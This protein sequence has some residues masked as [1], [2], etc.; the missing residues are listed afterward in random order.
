MRAWIG[1]LVLAWWVSGAESAALAQGK[2]SGEAGP[3]TGA[4]TGPSEEPAEAPLPPLAPPPYYEA[5]LPEPFPPPV[6]HRAR[7]GAA[8]RLEGAPMGKDAAPDARMG[9]FGLSL[10]PRPSPSFAVD[11]G[12][13]FFGGRDFNGERRTEQTFTIDPM[14]FLNPR[15]KVSVYLFAGLG[16]AGARVE[17]AGGSVSRYRYV[18]VNGGGGVELRF[19]RRVAIDADFLAFVRDRTDRESARYPEFIDPATGR[20][21]NTSQGIVLR[22]GVVY[23]W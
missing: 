18:G 19:W 13:D 10:R 16:L 17:H 2:G 6:R 3:A 15:S 14:L 5:P 11:F 7:W 12:L 21:T 8:F 20:F 23:Y 9:G 1:A 4:G 22:A